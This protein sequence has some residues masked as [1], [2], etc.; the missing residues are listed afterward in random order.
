M[1]KDTA[2]DRVLAA[3]EERDLLVRPGREG[4]A[5]VQCPAHDDR[6]P[7]LHVTDNDEGRVLLYC[8]AGCPIESVLEAL[9]LTF[10]DLHDNRGDVVYSYADGRVVHRKPYYIDKDGGL[11]KKFRQFGNTKGSPAVLYHLAEMKDA[12]GRGRTIYVVEGEADVHA[13]EA[14][15]RAATCSPQGAGKWDL[16]DPSPLYG[17]RAVIVV[18]DK[19]KPGHRHAK[20][21]VASLRDH[22]RDLWVVEAKQGKDATEHIQNGLTADDFVV[23][24]SPSE[25]HDTPD[26]ERVLD[27]VREFVAD[28]CVLGGAHNEV[29]VTLWIAHTWVVDAFDFT[30]RLMLLSAVKG[31][32]KTRVLEV[33]ELLS[34]DGHLLV[35][36]T[37]ATLFR[38]RQGRTRTLCLDEMDSKFGQVGRR[39]PQAESIRTMLNQGWQRGSRVP[40]TEQTT[41]GFTVA[42]YDPF[43]PVAL[44][45]IG[46]MPETLMDR[47]VIVHMRKR[48]P[49]EPVQRL[50]RRLIATRAEQ[51]RNQLLN[52]SSG[53]VEEWK[54]RLPE[55]ELPEE[56]SDRQQDA[57][58]P[59]VLVADNAGTRWGALAREAAVTISRQAEADESDLRLLLLSDIR[60]LFLRNLDWAER[61][62]TELGIAL[63]SLTDSP[64]LELDHNQGLTPHRL[65]RWLHDFGVPTHRVGTRRAFRR[66]DL[67]DPWQ[68]HLPPPNPCP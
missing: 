66:V 16:V 2:F 30:P 27:L 60:D 41:N 35:S 50:R 7:S 42:E 23:V 31:C 46:V 44:A 14:I 43:G 64:W 56:L 6:T 54:K 29:A 25:V 28:F 5:M 22:V 32:G 48:L 12:I 9:G 33:A 63:R 10:A 40:R 67:E 51:L 52:W 3:C 49:S 1:A 24:A 45:G 59:L 57:W 17:A 8:H 58:E 65:S 39:D 21:V 53:V 11:A 15:G 18:Q 62:P 4:D 38:L 26:G 34:Q 37:E 20:Q 19:D 68:R 61:T 55:T 13:M 36:P 47:S